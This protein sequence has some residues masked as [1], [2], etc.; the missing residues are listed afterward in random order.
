MRGRTTADHMDNGDLGDQQTCGLTR[1]QE[2]LDRRE[3]VKLSGRMPIRWVC[4]CLGGRR[5]TQMHGGSLTGG[6]SMLWGHGVGEGNL[7]VLSFGVEA[8][9]QQ[10][11]QVLRG[12]F[13]RHRDGLF[14]RGS[15]SQWSRK[16]GGD[17]RLR[18]ECPWALGSWWGQRQP[19]AATPTMS[20]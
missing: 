4:S 8:P 1:T 9:P 7:G 17:P 5:V 20:V 3:K 10:W 2:T 12:V 11:I 15:I 13:Q 6:G 16:R 19:F 18:R 14:L